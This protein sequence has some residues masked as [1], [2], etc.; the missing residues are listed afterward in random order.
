MVATGARDVNGL[1]GNLR[2]R[3]GAQ[4]RYA[5]PTSTGPGR[6]EVRG[7]A[8]IGVALL[9]LPF[10]ALAHGQ[11]PGKTVRVGL[12]EY[13]APNPSSETRW[14]ASARGSASSDTRR[15]GT[16]R[17]RPAGPRGGPTA[18]PAWPGS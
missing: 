17:S 13:G 8:G 2:A 7:L 4:P 11:A 1:V 14:D 5:R 12:L 6:H 16:W 15:S 10:A 3:N 18:C 9:S